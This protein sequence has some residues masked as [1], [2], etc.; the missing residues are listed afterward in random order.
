[1]YAA[2]GDMAQMPGLMVDKTPSS[3]M[4]LELSNLCPGADCLF[5]LSGCELVDHMN[6]QLYM[7]GGDRYASALTMIPESF[8]HLLIVS[9]FFIPNI[10][11]VRLDRQDEILLVLTNSRWDQHS[12]S[13]LTS[14]SSALALLAAF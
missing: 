5:G 9:A 1:M 8:I 14:S 3:Q 7:F 11:G 12:Q 2:Y 4:F 6:V 13:T 10:L